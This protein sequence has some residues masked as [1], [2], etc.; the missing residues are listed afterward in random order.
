[1]IST[2]ARRN[3]TYD[4]DQKTNPIRFHLLHMQLRRTTTGQELGLSKSAKSS[5]VAVNK[6][7]MTEISISKAL[8]ITIN[9]PVVCIKKS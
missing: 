2:H 4:G 7:I 9:I 6:R 1:M 3:K 5:E 8:I